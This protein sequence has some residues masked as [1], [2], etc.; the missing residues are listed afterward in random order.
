MVTSSFIYNFENYL[1][2]ERKYK[3]R[4]GL[5]TIYVVKYYKNFKTICNYAIK[6]D[7]VEKNPFKKYDEN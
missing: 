6:M 7:L 1:K 4:R 5:K 3:G 2:F